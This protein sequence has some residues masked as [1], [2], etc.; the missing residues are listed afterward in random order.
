[1]YIKKILVTIALLGLLVCAYFAYNIYNA[2]F[3]PNT[4]FNN[5]KATLFIEP[6]TH[7][8]TLLGL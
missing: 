6:F 5:E 2:I 4:A 7:W 3:Q 8:A 1:M